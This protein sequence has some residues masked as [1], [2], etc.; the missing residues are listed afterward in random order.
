[1]CLV[2]QLRSEMMTP[3]SELWMDWEECCGL[4]ALLEEAR[5][6]RMHDPESLVFDRD[7]EMRHAR[8]EALDE[9]GAFQLIITG[10]YG[11]RAVIPFVEEPKASVVDLLGLI[12]DGADHLP[13][14]DGA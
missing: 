1:M 3:S 6:G 5:F 13:K 10:Q 11:I 4:I 14:G 7:F 8:T 2:L 9:E 12:R